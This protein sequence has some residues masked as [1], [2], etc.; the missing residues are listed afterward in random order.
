MW[1]NVLVGGR[2]AE[3][4]IGRSLP[5]KPIK[6]AGMTGLHIQKEGIL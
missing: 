2:E 3:E 1:Y 4:R 6:E 5:A